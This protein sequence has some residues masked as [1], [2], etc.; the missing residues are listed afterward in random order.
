MADAPFGCGMERDEE[1]PILCD[2]CL[3]DNPLVRMVKTPASAACRMCVQ[4][5]TVF[6]WRPNNA[7][8]PRATEVCTTCA[9]VQ[10]V[11]QTCILDL[12]YGVPIQI[13]DEALG[14]GETPASSEN[15]RFQVQQQQDRLEAAGGGQLTGA[16]SRDASLGDQVAMREQDLRGDGRRGTGQPYAPPSSRVCSFFAKGEECKRGAY[17]PYKHERAAGGAETTRDGG[18]G[19]RARRHEGKSRRD[20]DHSSKKRDSNLRFPAPFEFA[21]VLYV[22]GVAEAVTEGD[23]RDNFHT[24]GEINFVRLAR[25]FKCAFV[26]F[27]S[28]YAAQRAAERTMG[29][30]VVIKGHKVKIIWAKQDAPGN[31]STPRGG[32]GAPAAPSAPKADVPAIPAALGGSAPAKPSYSAMNAAQLGSAPPAPAAADGAR[33]Q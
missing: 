10:N 23:L 21:K 29:R 19:G 32:S 4:P 7:V 27:K 12:D 2:A 20:G 30:N 24:Y 15:R 31:R 16:G 9:K 25:K 13:R 3:G 18:A 6:R 5:M 11:C 28:P 17:C 33:K 8:G 26:A 14:R 22:G 1:F